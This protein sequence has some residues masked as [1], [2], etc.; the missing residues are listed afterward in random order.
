MWRPRRPLGQDERLLWTEV[1]KSVRPLHGKKAEHVNLPDHAP[2]VP[3]PTVHKPPVKVGHFEISS[4]A[5]REPTVLTRPASDPVLRMDARTYAK[6]RRGR[7]VPEA[8]I[9]LH[10]MTVAEA[11]SALIA[12]VLRAQGAGLRL[13]LVI[14][15]KGKTGSDPGNGTGRG[16]VLRQQVPHWLRLNPLGPHVLQ[17]AEAH[18]SH[19]GSGALYVYLRRSG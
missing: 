18:V 1:A 13:V 3:V 16:G 4:R 7:L 15:G 19:G 11:H 14:T 6:L 8:R 12:F 17:V 10:G 5:A 2:I 9:D